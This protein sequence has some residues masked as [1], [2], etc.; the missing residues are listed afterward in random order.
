MS[1]VNPE[2]TGN[3]GGEL[4]EG[5][6]SFLK[7]SVGLAR[8]TFI[9]IEVTVKNASTITISPEKRKTGS[10]IFIRKAKLPNQSFMK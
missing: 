5:H 6:H 2:S 4:V 3:E 9:V 8:A 1:G 7:A 10:P